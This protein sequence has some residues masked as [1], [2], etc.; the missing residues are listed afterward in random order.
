MPGGS[1][2]ADFKG[3]ICHDCK[4]NLHWSSVGG[5]RWSVFGGDWEGSPNNFIGP[6]RDDN[7]VVQELY[8][9]V[10]VQRHGRIDRFARFVFEAQNWRS[11]A[12]ENNTNISSIGFIGP[13]LDVGVHF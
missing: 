13:R 5:A 7:I 12:L 2:A 9:G 11:D 6:I 8:G 3:V 4:H 10:E 1:V